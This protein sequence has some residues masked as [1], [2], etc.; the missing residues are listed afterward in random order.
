MKDWRILFVHGGDTQL[1]K[2]ADALQE[3][4]V[5]A[6]VYGWGSDPQLQPR[7]QIHVPPGDQDSAKRVL[8]SA[9]I[10]FVDVGQIANV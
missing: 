5:K 6:E 4:G 1:K 7:R 8:E 3:A 2:A 9:G 10:Q